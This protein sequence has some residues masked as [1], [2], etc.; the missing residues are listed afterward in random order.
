MTKIN[1]HSFYWHSTAFKIQEHSLHI[2]SSPRRQTLP[3]G[4]AF[5]PQAKQL[6]NPAPP[7]RHIN[8]SLSVYLFLDS[9]P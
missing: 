4:K 5:A 3:S 7:P 2:P 9:E 1:S 6:P 8:N